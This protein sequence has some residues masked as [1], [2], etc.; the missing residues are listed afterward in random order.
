M[1]PR[2]LT[3]AD[4]KEHCTQVYMRQDSD[5]QSVLLTTVRWHACP[6]NVELRERERHNVLH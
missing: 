2:E 1:T 3:A 5:G 6:G 4:A